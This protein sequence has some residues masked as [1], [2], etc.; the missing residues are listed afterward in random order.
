MPGSPGVGGVQ[1]GPNSIAAL[2]PDQRGR[3]AGGLQRAAP[4]GGEAYGMPLKMR[5]A[6]SRRPSSA[7]AVVVTVGRPTAG[8]LDGIAPPNLAQDKDSIAKHAGS[9]RPK[10]P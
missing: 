5:I 3:V 9:A 8:E 7:P 2:T 10:Y 6:P 4:T 1:A